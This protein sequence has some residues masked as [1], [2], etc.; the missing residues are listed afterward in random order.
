MRRIFSRR[1][2][3]SG[4]FIAPT[5]LSGDS[6]LFDVDCSSSRKLK[7]GDVGMFSDGRGWHN[8]QRKFSVQVALWHTS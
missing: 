5:R 6:P 2:R 4:S 1:W 8:G 7:R 3:Y